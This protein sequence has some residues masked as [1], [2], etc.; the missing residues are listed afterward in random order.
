MFMFGIMLLLF[1]LKQFWGASDGFS[2]NN[3]DGLLQVRSHRSDHVGFL[4]PAVFKV[5]NGTTIVFLRD[6]NNKN[7]STFV[8]MV[9]EA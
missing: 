8:L 2:K 9:L 1:P 4:K 3:S 6:L 7:R 5:F